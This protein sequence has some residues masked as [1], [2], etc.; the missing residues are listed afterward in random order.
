MSEPS[1][2]LAGYVLP[3]P[4]VIVPGVSRGPHEADKTVQAIRRLGDEFAALRPETVVV[5]SPHAPMFSDYL[6]VYDQIVLKGD[7]SR[8][9]A[10]KAGL[11]KT[12]DQ[13]FLAEFI[14]LLDQA[15]IAGGS[16]TPSQMRTHQI[17]TDLDHGV[18]VP[19]YFL[20]EAF[21][22][23][24]LVAMSC[25][26]L[27]MPELY[28]I[29]TLIRQA[30]VKLNRRVVIVAS[31]DQ[32]HKVNRE[33][34]YG[35]S[36]EGGKY[37]NLVVDSLKNGNLSQLL[38]IGS[39]LRE[40]AAECGY[41]SM[42]MLCG[43]F[44]RQAVSTEVF[45]Y[46]APYGIGY[47]VAAIRPD[48]QKTG[49]VPDAWEE[50]LAK[51]RSD[52]NASR[53]ASS[54]PVQI[55]RTTLEAYVR[56]K[57]HLS[58]RDFKDLPDA[59]PLFRKRGGAFVSLKKFGELR[60]CIGTTAATTASLADEIVQNALSAGLHDPRFEP[61]REDELIDLTYSVDVLGEPEP[62][63]GRETLDPAVYGVIVRSGSRTGLLLPDLEGVDS[64]EDQLAIAC[65]KAGIRS[66]ESYQ[67]MR[68]KVTRYH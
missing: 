32:S 30:A 43:A 20:S 58:S 63:S 6:F 46:E 1:G 29:G 10:P 41:R 13:E 61:V 36:P 51:S 18:V 4:P 37:D 48:L 49:Q 42:V 24:K 38:G 28:Q 50:S 35:S 3:H 66:G 59:E 7:L 21:S 14:R 64:V 39:Q 26:N 12:C 17:E 65:R 33:S 53:Q 5:I 44:S 25:S 9:G 45:S 60:G 31:G 27:P 11:S 40:R 22:D 54:A 57:K 34:P 8:F 56:E 2:I 67:I 47:C 23:Y 15:G 55:A 62:V 52:L 68:F 19:M 16:L